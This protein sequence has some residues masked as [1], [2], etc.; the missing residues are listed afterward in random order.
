MYKLRANI[1]LTLKPDNTVYALSYE[2]PDSYPDTRHPD[3]GYRSFTEPD[4]AAEQH[5]EHWDQKRIKLTIPDGS[6]DMT[7]GKST[8]LESNIDKLNGIS[9][10]KGCYI[11][12]ELT[13]RMH[14]RGLAKKHL[15]TVTGKNLPTPGDTI[16]IENKTIGEMRSSSCNYGLALLKDTEIASLPKIGLELFRK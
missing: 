2:T 14:Y 8:L 13:A 3:M 1:E 5:F 10:D 7:E 11:G 4:N 12:Q 9:F 15:Y 6:R 16:R